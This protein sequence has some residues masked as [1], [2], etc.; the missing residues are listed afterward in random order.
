MRSAGAAAVVANDQARAARVTGGHLGQKEEVFFV[1]K[2][3]QNT[4]ARAPGSTGS[5]KTAPCAAPN[6]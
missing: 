2:K 3:N 4:F 5:Y 6:G 1:E